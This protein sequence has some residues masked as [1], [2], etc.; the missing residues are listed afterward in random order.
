MNLKKDEK[1][2]TSKGK[3]NIKKSKAS[4]TSKVAQEKRASIQPTHDEA[5]LTECEGDAQNETNAEQAVD[6]VK[7]IEIDRRT[8][9]MLV[10]H[11]RENLGFYPKVVITDDEDDESN[12][13]EDQECTNH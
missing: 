1:G 2:K 10:N 3:K 9:S 4:S 11:V 5:S 12:A 6:N 8:A 7:T 13:G